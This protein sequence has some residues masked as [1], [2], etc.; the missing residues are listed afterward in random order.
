MSPASTEPLPPETGHEL[1]VSEQIADWSPSPAAEAAHRRA[2]ISADDQDQAQVHRTGRGGADLVADLGQHRLRDGL[3]HGEDDQGLAALRRPRDLHARDV[4]TGLAEDLAD[5]A[6]HTGTVL[7]TQDDHVVGERQV[8]VVLADGHDLLEVLRACQR[9]GDRDLLAAGERAADGDHV[10]VVGRL[11]AGGEADLDTALLGEERGVDVGDGLVH[12]VLEDALERREFQ[13]L[14]VVL[15]DL[16]I[17]LDVEPGR[18]LARE[19]GEDPAELLGER[20]AGAYVLGDDA[21]LDVDRVRDQLTGEREADGLGDRDARLLLGLVGGGAEVRGADDLVELEERGVRA[22]L[23]RVHIEAGAGD[24][25]LLECG[26][27]RLLVDDPAARGVDD[28]DR[29][30]HL[31][32][33]LVPDETEGL[34]GLG[35]VHGDE[36]G[37]FEELVQAEELDA[38]LRGAG[39]LDVGVVRDDL[40]A[41]GRHALRDEDTDAAEA[42]DAE[43]LL[44]ELDPGVLGA[45]PLAVLQG[46]VG[47]GDVA[48]GGDQQTAGQLGGGHDVGGRGVDDH[49]AGLGGR[50]DVDVVQTDARAGHHAELLRGGDRLGVD[51]RGGTHQDGVDVGDRGEEFGAVSAVAVPDLEIR[52]QGVDR[53]GRQLFSD[54]YDR[55]RAHVSPHKSS[56]DGRPDGRRRWRG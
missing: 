28:A 44:A 36:V 21:A 32:Q 25:A 47:L 11:G 42:D 52:T 50:G 31:V 17:H 39:G 37:D 30:L 34:G 51:L 46:G 54:E 6:D 14:D 27:Q 26:V 8:H 40:H 13:H 10:A 33:R 43:D 16:A 9:A 3:V 2:P 1:P 41:E 45:L 49:H 15:G 38:H 24:A 35:Q 56:A 53:C 20:Q 23:L 29:G 7:V 5:R 22:G 55:F 18:D 48:R 19:G 12:D 4:Q